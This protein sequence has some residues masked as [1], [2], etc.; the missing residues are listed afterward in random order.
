MMQST[1]KTVASFF[2]KYYTNLERTG[3]SKPLHYVQMKRQ[4]FYQEVEMYINQHTNNYKDR[5]YASG[6]N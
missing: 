6:S 2:E 5:T 4:K 3:K 1:N